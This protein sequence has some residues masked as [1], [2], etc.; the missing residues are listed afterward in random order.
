[1]LDPVCE[2]AR[3]LRSRVPEEDEKEKKKF[4]VFGAKPKEEDDGTAKIKKA[5]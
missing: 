3:R 2:I 5:F 4:F 1:M